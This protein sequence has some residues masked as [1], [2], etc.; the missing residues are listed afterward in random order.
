M[1][2]VWYDWEICHDRAEVANIGCGSTSQSVKIWSPQ[3][4]RTS[5]VQHDRR[6]RA[7]DRNVRCSV[8]SWSRS[9]SGWS[10]PT[11][12]GCGRSS[13]A[14]PSPSRCGGCRSGCRAGAEFLVGMFLVAIGS[15]FRTRSQPSYG[16]RGD[17][18]TGSRAIGHDIHR[19][20][21]RPAASCRHL[22]LIYTH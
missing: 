17:D 1:R 6:L 9:T 18:Q 4:E 13:P 21:P 15:A 11:S 16:V 20:P 14:V 22:L 12:R 10:W 19:G 8:S 2:S 7:R 3:R 5:F